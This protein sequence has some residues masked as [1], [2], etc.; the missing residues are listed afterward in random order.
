MDA[1]LQAA[2]AAYPVV[3]RANPS[4]WGQPAASG[5]SATFSAAVVATAIAEGS[6][7]PI[8]FDAA[9]APARVMPLPITLSALLTVGGP[10]RRFA[11]GKWGWP[12]AARPDEVP[13]PNVDT[14][15]VLAAISAGTVAVVETDAKGTPLTVALPSDPRASR[16]P[17][18]PADIGTA[19]AGTTVA[20]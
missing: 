13:L 3:N 16:P 9:G 19:A 11:D 1:A 17:L 6:A 8:S 15:A 5:S 14:A 10:V 4:T 20:A 2:L 12:S 18:R 7:M